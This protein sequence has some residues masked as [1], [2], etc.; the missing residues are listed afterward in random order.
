MQKGHGALRG[1]SV[2]DAGLCVHQL[3][4]DDGEVADSFA[5][6]GVD[7]VADGGG[8][9]GD[10]DLADVEVD[11]DVVLGEVFVDGAAVDGVDDRCGAP[12][13]FGCKLL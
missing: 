1:L 5:G 7:G 8:D 13:D 2:C 3:V 4:E 11:G 9:A 12:F 6:G 10:V